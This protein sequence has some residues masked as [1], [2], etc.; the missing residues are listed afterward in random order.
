M[1]PLLHCNFAMQV[2]HQIVVAL[3]QWTS[4]RSSR[5]FSPL[6]SKWSATLTRFRRAKSILSRPCRSFQVS[7]GH[8]YLQKQTFFGTY[9]IF[10]IISLLQRFPQNQPS[11][12]HTV[13]NRQA[14]FNTRWCKGRD[15][16]WGCVESTEHHPERLCCHRPS[17]SFVS[18]GSSKSS[19]WFFGPSQL[20]FDLYQRD[21][22][23]LL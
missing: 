11:V 6:S 12:L 10:Q 1:S 4:L 16:R 3:P 5:P 15:P 21:C 7:T 8:W 2:N 14:S 19:T 23:P 13:P 17:T 22:L 9:W 18:S 20:A